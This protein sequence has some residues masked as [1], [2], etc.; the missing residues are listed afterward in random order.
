MRRC[1]NA[2]NK[3][4]SL[5]KDFEVPLVVHHRG[6]KAMP[7]WGSL[8]ATPFAARTHCTS[9]RIP[10]RHHADEIVPSITR[11]AMAGAIREC[12]ELQKSA[13]VT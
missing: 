7:Y 3:V 10:L 13:S 8:P 4:V 1:P 6:G 12:D 11:A 5:R 9:V 2:T